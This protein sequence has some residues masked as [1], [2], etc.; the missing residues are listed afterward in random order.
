MA[1]AR[2]RA[3][4]AADVEKLVA[5]VVETTPF[6]A[7]DTVTN[8]NEEPAQTRTTMEQTMDQ[9]SKTVETFT[10]A[11]E[12]AAAFSRGNMEAFTQ[13]TQ[14]YMAGVQDLSKQALSLLQGLTEHSLE[15]AKALGQVKSLKEAADIHTSYSRA[16]VEKS[17]AE[18]AKLQEQAVKL[19]EAAV[20]PLTARVTLAV[21]T[22]G[23]PLAA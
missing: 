18:G 22:F 16:A 20:A 17:L 9:A 5:G 19:V 7:T 10:K 23:K 3:A 6:A 14:V 11:A 4:K 2:M 21:E 8:I 13:A 1:N 12:D 15:G